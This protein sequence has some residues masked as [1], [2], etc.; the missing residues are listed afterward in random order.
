[1]KDN[2]DEIIRNT[3]QKDIK[4]SATLNQSVFEKA[5]EIINESN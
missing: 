2:I 5:K 4:P 1:M 3:L